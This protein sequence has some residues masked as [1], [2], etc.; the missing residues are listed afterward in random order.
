MNLPVVGSI[1]GL[2]AFWCLTVVLLGVTACVETT[3][4]SFRRV[5]DSR[6]DEAFVKPGVD[7]SRYRRLQPVPLEIYYYEGQQPPLAEDLDRVR[8]IFREAFLAAIGDDYELVDEAG[9]DVLGV[10]AS[11]VDLKLSPALGTLP[12]KGRAAHLVANGELTFFMELTDSVSGEVLA[13]AADQ[14]KPPMTAAA[15]SG[16]EWAETEIA[17]QRWAAMFRDFLDENL[18]G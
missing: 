9:P 8:N 11:L 6:A 18:G 12:V 2:R 4:E 10:R 5:P 7:F 16:R 3:V 17:A 14:E 13:R 15:T 1:G